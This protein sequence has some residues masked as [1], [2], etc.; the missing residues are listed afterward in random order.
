MRRLE[1]FL[2]QT[3]KYNLETITNFILSYMWQVDGLFESKHIKTFSVIPL[4]VLHDP[5]LKSNVKSACRLAS[6]PTILMTFKLSIENK[7]IYSY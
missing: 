1:S 4:K 5:Y 7:F 2:R 3:L 6:Q